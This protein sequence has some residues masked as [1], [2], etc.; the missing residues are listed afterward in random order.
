MACG[1]FYFAWDDRERPPAPVLGTI[2]DEN[3]PGYLTYRWMLKNDPKSRIED[4]SPELEGLPRFPAKPEDWPGFL[5]EHRQ[6]FESAWEKDTLGQ[7]WIEI[8]GAMKTDAYFPPSTPASPILAFTPLRHSV[9][10]RWAKAG[11]LSLDGN[12]D[13]A[14]LT[15]LPL[16]SASHQLQRS[17]PTM[18]GQMIAIV[19]IKGT[20][21]RLRLIVETGKLSP[22]TQAELLTA[23]DSAPPPS[24][25][26]RNMFL[27]ERL[28]ARATFENVHDA[29]NQSVTMITHSSGMASPPAWLHPLIYNPNR[30]EREY[31]DLLSAYQEMASLRETEKT[32][33]TDKSVGEEM[34]GWNL[35]NPVGRALQSMAIPAFAKIT[36]QTWI[37]EDQRSMLV[38]QLRTP[39]ER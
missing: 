22:Q 23:L 10:T 20:Q 4:M 34:G 16:L 3:N 32:A 1:L 6:Q 9:Q 21:E 31:A 5:A 19:F 25:A 14:V 24:L 17:A 18:L 11:L 33:K 28:F 29:M 26:F 12:H 7:T 2:I 37:A 15:L 36:D 30:T 39:A 27:G 38:Q 13:A 8:I 35:K